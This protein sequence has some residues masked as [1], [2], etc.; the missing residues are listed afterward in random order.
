[1]RRA[2]FCGE[3]RER[4]KADG[5]WRRVAGGRRGGCG[6]DFGDLEGGMVGLGLPLGGLGLGCLSGRVSSTIVKYFTLLVH[7]PLLGV[8]GSIGDFSALICDWGKVPNVQ[9]CTMTCSRSRIAG[10]TVLLSLRIALR[11]NA[12]LNRSDRNRRR[13]IGNAVL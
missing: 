10:A 4:A 7:V 6:G 3:S 2:A 5:G 13:G 11:P 8:A 1:M 12:N 9:R